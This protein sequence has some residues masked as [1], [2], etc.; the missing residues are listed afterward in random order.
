MIARTSLLLDQ[1]FFGVLA[2][3]LNLIEDPTCDTA[4]TNGESLGFSPTFAATLTDD[5][6]MAVVAHEVMHCACGHPWRRG[7]RDARRFNIAADY[8]IN[9]I[10]TEARMRL[11]DCALNDPQY[12]GRWAEWI[13][14]RLPPSP[15]QPNDP[16]G[17]G[18]SDAGGL[19]EVRDAPT[20]ATAPTEAD[21]QQQTAQAIAAGKARGNLPASIRERIEEATRSRVDW[22]S[23][24][25]RYAQEIA[26]S[27]YSWSR[28][29]VR[30]IPCGLYLP[31]LRSHECGRLAIGIAAVVHQPQH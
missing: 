21:W 30:Y 22:R 12:A 27:D 24:L 31:E 15:P 19:G 13:Y 20:E 6:L 17:S 23:L 14:D 10:L 7:S 28:P 26:R 4:W 11:P 5:E 1:P 9:P 29:N 2:L 16:S 18:Q 25:R 8:A 3:A